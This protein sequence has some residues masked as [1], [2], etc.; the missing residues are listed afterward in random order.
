MYYELVRLL[1]FAAIFALAGALIIENM[2][3]KPTI[4]AEDARNLA[5]VDAVYGASAVLVFLFGLT[6]WLWVGKPSAFYSANPLFQIKLGLFILLAI[7]SIYPTLFFIRHRR[8]E[9]DAIRVPNA[10][11][12]L[13]KIELLL[14]LFIPVLAFLM[15]R[16]IGLSA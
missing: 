15:A 2:A 5:K 14:L 11:A 3:L 1:H 10:V 8:A 16:G 12:V 9:T 13:I 4:N 7:L 6:L